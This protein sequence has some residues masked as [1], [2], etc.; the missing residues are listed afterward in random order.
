MKLHYIDIT[1]IVIYLLSV[2]AIGFAIKRWATQKLESY[3]LANR[4]MPWWVLG[5]AGCSSYIDIGGTMAMVGLMFYTGFKS[6]WVTHLFWG[7]LIIC[8]YMAFQAKWIRRSGVMTFAEWNRTRFGEGPDAEAARIAAAIFLLI[9]MVCNLAFIAV[10]IGKFAE[11]FLPLDRW[12]S[13]LIVFAAAGFYV[14]L[15]GFFGVIL[16]DMLQ[17]LLIAIG[18]VLLT[19]LVFTTCDPVALVATR[20]AEWTSLTLTW[21]MWDGFVES[22]PTAYQH[23]EVLGPVLLAGSFWLIFRVAAGPNV[24]DFQFFLTARSSRDAALAGGV[25]TV[26]YTM[27]WILGAAFLI[28]GLHYF[29]SQAGGDAEKI[30]PMVL[31]ALPI[32][33]SGLFIAVLL[34]ALMST[35]DAMINV[36]SSVVVNDFLKRYLAPARS[37]RWLVRAGQLASLAALGLGFAFSLLVENI[38]QIWETMVHVVVTMVLVPAT[39]RWHWWRFGARAFVAGMIGSALMLGG[40]VLFFGNLPPH[41]SLPIDTLN[42]LVVT[43]IAGWLTRPTH[44]D[45]L[46]DFYARVKPFGFWAP[47]RR[48][49]VR[50][51]RVADNDREPMFD[52][53]NGGQA[54]ELQFT[55]AQI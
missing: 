12:A 33:I 2:V 1:I 23:F 14:T 24:W 15:G 22:A 19:I 52:M 46:V 6:V 4:S 11:E 53:L 9:L 20:P 3:F 21:N 29:G 39:M 43:L 28:L 36:T 51:G 31:N 27:R 8:F 50:R 10:G 32:G 30:M 17:T 42:C 38:I 41:I 5:L 47:I 18:S 16:T 25:W 7:W 26:A 55:L 35:L 40:R 13:T 34:A 54:V 37:E 45:V 44:T 49:A 48:E